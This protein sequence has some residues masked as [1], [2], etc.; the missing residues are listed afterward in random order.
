[1]IN[2]SQISR[3]A[4]VSAV[5][6][7]T[8]EPIHRLSAAFAPSQSWWVVFAEAGNDSDEFA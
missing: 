4:D 5:A 3:E 8:N 2:I 1:M 6:R 7:H